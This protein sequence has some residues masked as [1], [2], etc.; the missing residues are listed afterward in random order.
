MSELPAPPSRYVVGIDLGTTNS[1]VAYVDTAEKPWRVR[2]FPVRQLVAPSTVEARDGLPSFHYQAPAAEAR[3]EALRL[4][5]RR[6]APDWAVGW[7]AREAGARNPARLIASAKSWLCHA[8]VDRTAELL[9]WQGAPDVARLSP[10][11]ATARL[12][13]HLRDAWSAEFP[14]HPLPQQDVVITLPASFDE[15]ARELTIRAAKLAELPRIALV[16]EP[17]AAFYA[18]VDKH[19][20][21]WQQRVQPG[22]RILVCDIGGGTTDFTLI[23]VQAA[24]RG[25]PGEVRFHRVAVGDHL[26]LGG[27]NL[28]LAL[29]Q[30]LEPRLAGEGRQ[31]PPQQWDVL[32]RLARGVKELLLGDDPPER[33]AVSLPASGARL[34]GGA[35]QAE[36]ARGEVEE[37]LVDGFLP[38]VPLD[39]HPERRRSGFQEFGLPYAA[40]SA[41]TRYLAAFLTAHRFTGVGA[42]A[43]GAEPSPPPRGTED[44]AR[45]D[46]LLFNGGFFASP[47]LRARLLEVLGSWFSDP[48]RPWQPQVLANERL[49][50]A[51]AR[52]AAYYGM[53]RRGEG[54]GIS[55]S[56]A[57]SYYIGVQNAGEAGG[58]SGAAV[59]IAPG[60]AE[61]GATWDVADLPL[62]L[63]LSEP[64]EFPLYV[65]STRLAD[66]PGDVA[67]L[68]REQLTP[69]PPIRTVLH[70][71]RRGAGGTALVR[72]QARVTEIGTLELACLEAEGKRSWRLQ[73]DVR[74]TMRTDVAAHESMAEGEGFLDESAWEGARGLLEEA[75]AD[76]AG[77]EP[78]RL[79]K[80]LVEALA[81][82][83][84]RWP[85]SL[86]RRMWET[87]WE[88]EAGRRRSPAHEARWLNLTGY[89]LRPGFGYAVDDWRVAETWRSV[90][91][92]LAFRSSLAESLVLWRRLAGGLS[93]GQ[94][95][96]VAEPLLAAVRQARRRLAGGAQRGGTATL[97][98]AES[99]ELW[100]L[101][102]ALELLEAPVKIELGDAVA[103]LL[104]KRKLAKV[105]EAMV[106]TLGRLGQRVPL[107]GML[108]TVVPS[109]SAAA[110]LQAVM[111]HEQGQPIDHW[112]AM[113]LARRTDDRRR[114]LDERVRAEAVD[115]LR[116]S[117]A[118]PH[119]IELVERGGRLDQ[120]EAAQTFGESL[121]AGL[122]LGDD[123]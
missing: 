75:F 54:V 9:P 66:R 104:P 105:R 90:Y 64:V 70:P 63:T 107:R 76:G 38:R 86:L 78:S 2:H 37:W 96:V 67:A 68:D 101:L 116:G 56:L 121:P 58:A 18:W 102:G 44:P 87:L 14:Q 93:R 60:D 79:V 57:R 115:W 83:R 27:D 30:R 16:E 53:V 108:N 34:V 11:E 65:S 74:S 120:Q 99:L 119:L 28:D 41:V 6:A 84:E 32:V 59:C 19:A 85:T 26:I 31:L 17:Q 73:F 62:R 69:L 48:G 91:G 15:V 100:R 122:R 61:P 98:P 106:W 95:A 4:P 42:G 25:A 5:W 47:Q 22:Q 36:V 50:L 23:R 39:A 82:P 29:A 10:V 118:G 92:K 123:G 71:A 81:L 51:V 111:R 3:Q 112:A 1:A 8:G 12:L 7:F 55:A 40:D 13:G 103:E 49:D 97:D 72:L 109:A 110:W 33:T 43:P 46:L 113:Q 35:L 24:E 80:R 117:S 89:A 20:D 88:L 52:G 114:D 77:G 21:D 45:P 94:Q